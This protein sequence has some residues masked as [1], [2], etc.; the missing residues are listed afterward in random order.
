[1]N[2]RQG[3]EQPQR[4][5]DVSGIDELRRVT[6]TGAGTYIGA[7]V[8]LTALAQMPLIA[9]RYRAVAEAALAIAAPGH[10]NLATVGG[11]LC[12]DTRCIFY[13]QSEWW[14]RA[15]GYCL[16]RKG[17]ACH[18]ASQ[19]GHCHAAFCGDLAPA[20]MV[21]GAEIEIAGCDGRRRIPLAELYSGDGRAHL[22]L[23][24]SE[25]VLAVHL[26][27]DPPPSRYAKARLRGAIDFPL[28]GAAIALAVENGK[29]GSLR[30]ALTGTNPR[31]ILLQ[32]ADA[33]LGSVLDD[34]ALQ[35]LEKLVQRQVSPMRTTIASAHYRR[36]VA[37][38][39][40]TRL[41]AELYC[42]GGLA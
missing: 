42:R 33:F 27:P 39:L 32:G 8:T 40:V 1:V 14:R 23:A 3:L 22:T 24:P 20:L 19:G 7:G 13:N 9:E 5:V 26:P 35:R 30:I 16:K 4:L 10:R 6:T 36:L 11:N 41:A 25:L 28:A 2:L 31:P 34:R 37:A 12:L 29:V 21:L 38:A 18:V 15:N 17:E